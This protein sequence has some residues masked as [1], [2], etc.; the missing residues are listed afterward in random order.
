M[1]GPRLPTR[2]CPVAGGTAGPRPVMSSRRPADVA[3]ALSQIRWRLA[4]FRTLTHL[5]KA[6]RLMEARLATATCRPA[7]RLA[8]ATCRTA[9]RHLRPALPT[10][11]STA[12][13]SRAAGTG[14]R[15]PRACRP[16]E[17]DIRTR[18]TTT[19]HREA[20]CL[21][22]A[23]SPVAAATGAMTLDPA[24]TV[25]LATTHPATTAALATRMGLTT[26][27]CLATARVG[28]TTAT[29]RTMD[30]VRPAAG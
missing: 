22:T 13:G 6:I 30:A 14:T 24:T 7:A 10:T 2:P 27:V 8:T 17:P 21:P 23:A 28:P 29:S 1:T 26:Q 25:A 18:L 4:D 5:F 19:S 11:T 15:A 9:G 3:G 20:G 16:P 12:G